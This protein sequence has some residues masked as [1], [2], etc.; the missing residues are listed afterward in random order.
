MRRPTPGAPD[1]T[2]CSTVAT[3][4]LERQPKA[5]Y[6]TR[7]FLAVLVADH[8]W[9]QLVCQLAVSRQ[10][11]KLAIAIRRANEAL[12]VVEVAN[13]QSPEAVPATARCLKPQLRT[14][15]RVAVVV[16]GQG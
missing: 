14:E 11:R 5:V 16:D 15:F 2:T 10:A 7:D 3:R 1:L 12:N 6:R 4:A 9:R 8:P 13:V